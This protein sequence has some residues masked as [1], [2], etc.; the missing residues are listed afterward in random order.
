MTVYSTIDLKIPKWLLR[1]N[2]IE[3]I[4]KLRENSLKSN[5]VTGNNN[6]AIGYN[7]IVGG[8]NNVAIGYNSITSGFS[9]VVYGL[10][11]KKDIRKNKVKII[12]KET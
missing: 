10:D 12:W 7:S 6:V 5:I 2:R 11:R 3:I 8:Y 1:M 9:N 4:F